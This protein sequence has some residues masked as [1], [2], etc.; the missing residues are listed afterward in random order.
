MG[1]TLDLLK[2]SLLKI[3]DQPILI[4]N[5]QY[6]MN[7]FTP[8]SDEMSDF[9]DFLEHKFEIQKMKVIHD[10]TNMNTVPFAMIRDELFHPTNIDNK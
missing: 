8:L 4:H 3:V 9:K 7:F 10:K 2:N 5:K 1:R 6:M